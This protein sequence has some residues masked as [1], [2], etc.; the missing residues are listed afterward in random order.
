M[1]EG[2]VRL[3]NVGRS[4]ARSLAAA[5]VAAAMVVG[6]GPAW[7]QSGTASVSGRVTDQQ[8]GAVPGATV[9]VTNAA[10]AVTRSVVTN[11][12]G[13][14]HLLAL[15]PGTYD[16][17]VTMSG[18][19]SAKV[20]K[21]ELRVD[22]QARQDVQL[23][24]GGVADESLTVVADSA[25]INSVDASMG[26]NMSEQ[27]IRNLPVE[28][29]NVVELLSLQPG[30]VYIPRASADA[31]DPRYGAVS[32]A[33]ADQQSV[34][35]DGV[36]VNDPQLQTAYSSAVRVT[37]DALQEFRVSTS[38]Y[39]ADM[40]RSSG[41]Q[42]SLV[43]KSGTNSFHGA[44]YALGRRTGT[45]S[46]EYFLKLS[47]L[48]SA[49]PNVAP[50]LDKD[51][52]GGSLGGPIRKDRV[53]FF[54]NYEQLKEESERP[55]VRSVPSGSFRDGVLMYRCAVPAQCPGGSVAGFS[56]NHSVQSGWYGLTPAQVAG[57][58]PLG[59]GPSRAASQYFRGFPMPNEP[60]LDG[61]NIMNYRFAGPIANDF[62]TYVARI[63]AKL[64][65][66]GTHHLFVRGNA[67][68]DT[69][70][71]PPQ[72]PDAPPRSAQVYKNYG[73]AVGY[74]WA[75]SSTLMNTFRYGMTKI[76]YDSTGR[77]A[78]N[79][80]TF[81]FI[82]NIDPI[83]FTTTR[84]TP[85]H[86]FVNE[87]S[88]L[89]NSHSLK[90][91]TNL[92]FIR[93]PSTRDSG[94]YISATV[95]PSWVA[96]VGRRYAPGNAAFCTTP[97]CNS[98]P[99]VAGIGAGPAPSFAAGYADAWLNI[100]G[101]LSQANL[102]ANYN[103][104]GSQ[105]AVGAPVSRE[106]ATD[107]Y[108][109][110]VQDSWRVRPNLT[111]TAGV[112]YSLYS[113]PYET[114]GQQ[115]AP[116]PGMGAW[117]AERESNMQAGIPSNRSP[118]IQFDLA[119]P[120]NGKKG[121]Y[122]WD[123]NNFGPRLAF[124]WTPKADGGLF[125]WLTGGDKMVVRGGYSKVFDRIGQGIARNFDENLAYGMSTSVSSPFGAPYETNPAVRFQNITTLP[126]T[127]PVAPA[128]GFPQTPPEH[129]NQITSSIDDSIKTPSAHMVNFV[130]GRELGKGFSIEA[131]FVG[132]YG[133]D[134]LTRRDLAMPLNLVDTRSGVD[135]FSAA[136]QMIKAAQSRGI[137][138]GS[139]ASAYQGLP[140]IAY[141]ENLF[142]GAAGGGLTATQAMTRA[143][144]Q[145]SPDYITALFEADEFCTP[146]CSIFGP[147]AYFAE[148]YDSLGSISSVGRSNYNALQATF[149]KRYSRGYQFDLNYTLG[150]SKDHGS[151][152]E[153]GGFF[154][155]F[156]NGGYTG[157]LINTWDP[158][159]QYGY[160]DF[161]VRHQVNFN[162]V[163]DLPLANGSSGVAKHLL[164]DWS[165]AGLVRWTSGFPFN[166]QN[167]RSCWTTNW[168][169]Q[170]NAE[171]VTPGQLPE[172]G[173]TKDAVDHRP[174]PF[175][176]ADAALDFFRLALPGEVGLRNSLRGDG[177][178]S[179]D[180]SLSKAIKVYKDH[181][182][183][184]RADVFN[185]TNTP[186][187][188]VGNVTMTPDRSPW[189]VYNGT[190]ATCDAQAG[191]C[192][193]FALRYEF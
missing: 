177:Y 145:N 165:L 17:S 16:L 47:Q 46:N 65:A 22:A 20:S 76:D 79:Y 35:L 7:A 108:E 102:R 77:V 15:P 156:G 99:A 150:W 67:Q 159:A 96:G 183:R 166:V 86:N 191:R 36:D 26:N 34:T 84:E 95:N 187:F 14:Y 139:A 78:G 141:W 182:L 142:P 73:L 41:P 69:L 169:L 40:G 164:G 62:K 131:G 3:S 82:D 93:I 181:R 185:L 91:G 144:M 92:R 5:V 88:W 180:M 117:F 192:M 151:Q 43:T 33:R 158:E 63:D 124:A 32:G 127:V 19:R 153:R 51:I 110:Y 90:F 135:Y 162:F 126:P 101:V 9:T 31:E 87:L 163:W 189:G 100:L 30:A 70:S 178:F 8:A 115:V 38:N 12:A 123:K 174:S 75:V 152:I 172:T 105:L 74:D 140:A 107:E 71:D 97:T 25:L 146:S 133:R 161:D 23:T 175:K 49:Q 147:Y 45:S 4:R 10:S 13:Q 28:A 118:I 80:N 155:N 179:I 57:I 53:F 128:G 149:R 188:D 119:G 68:D 170:G 136:Q 106:Y 120:A 24:V 58:D 109:F 134:L 21:L 112:R 173:T 176:D 113:P 27:A 64:N 18:F 160:S 104:D 48:G 148:Q 190:L 85:N 143:F 61:V 157:F 129:A 94:S 122:D 193:Q 138:G 37:Q 132:R 171:L 167:C 44:A 103:K 121:F 114:N 54:V 39:G 89:K 50:K 42:V 184:L 66:S 60:G 2:G 56:G 116:T 186:K 55:V 83:T 1:K 81:R 72:Y 168:N 130:V 6:A 125:G 98:V 52:L 29:R 111:V 11:Q 137:N 154:G 59:I